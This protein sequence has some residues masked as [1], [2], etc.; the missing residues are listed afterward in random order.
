MTLR[1]VDAGAKPAL[2]E[3]LQAYLA[4]LAGYSDDLT[5][6]GNGEYH[7]PYLDFYWLDPDRRAWW[8]VNGQ[9]D[10]AG[11][12]LVRRYADPADGRM[13][14]EVA[15]FYIR[16]ECRGTGLSALAAQS[17]WQAIPGDWLLRYY[18]KNR[19]AARF[20]TRLVGETGVGVMETDLGDQVEIQFRVE[21][22]P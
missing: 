1:P 3:M 16:P 12:I 19:P 10:E 21:A 2:R 13:I 5:T 9:G 15:E 7:Y 6:D 17:A 22:N 14:S 4:E 18:K 20:W 11:F 8:V